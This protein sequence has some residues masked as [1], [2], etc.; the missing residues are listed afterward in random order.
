VSLFIDLANYK[1]LWVVLIAIAQLRT[2]ART[3]PERSAP[4]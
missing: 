4:G 1:Y 3:R 2:V